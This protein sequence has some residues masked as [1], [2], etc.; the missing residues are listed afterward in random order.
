[1]AEVIDIKRTA[2]LGA[3]VMGAQIAALLANAG[4]EVVLLDRTEQDAAGGLERALQSRPP[5]FFTPGLAAQVKTASFADLSVLAEVDWIVEAI[6]E[7]LGIKQA[8]LSQVEEYAKPQAIISTNTSGLSIA[9]IAAVRG[10]AFNRRFLG[11]HFFNPP[12]YMRLV[13]FIAGP[14]TA[15]DIIEG[16]GAFVEDRLGKGVVEGRDTPNF[17]ANRLGVF[18]LMDVLHAM[19][20]EGLSV[21]EVDALT[22]PLLGRPRSASLRLCDIIGLDTLIH[23]ARTGYEKLS[24]DA[25]R[26]TF[27]PPAAVERMLDAGLLGEKSK[28]GF[29]RKTEQGI[30]ALDLANGAFRPLEAAQLGTLGKTA[31]GLEDR[32]KA[33]WADEGRLGAFARDHLLRVLLYA[34]EHAGEI[35]ADLVQI[36]RAM[37]WGF[38]WEAGPFELWDL[39]GVEEVVKHTDQVPDLVQQLLD[40]GQSHF[41]SRMGDRSKVFALANR[42][43]VEVPPDPGEQ[44]AR[45]LSASTAVLGNESAYLVEMDDDLGVLVLQGKMNVMR[46]QT[47]E[48]IQQVAASES[49]SGL[50]VYGAGDLFTA[51]ADLTHMAGLAAAGDWQG[52]DDFVAAFQNAIMALRYA[53]FPVVAAPRG[54]ALGGGCELCLAADGRIV[55]AESRLGLV[56]TRVGLIPGGG[57]CK[58]M[59]R[60]LGAGIEPG[61]RTI[62]AGAIADNALQA[63][64][65]LLLDADDAIAMNETTLVL[66]ALQEVKQLRVS[67]APPQKEPVRVAGAAGREVL[68]QWLGQ[69]VEAERLSLHDRKVGQRLAYV[70]CGGDRTDEIEEQD[71][72][73]LE[74]EAFLHLFGLEATRARIDHMLKTGKPLRN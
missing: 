13:E 14:A 55:A 71:L 27:L 19:E 49:L 37:K 38:N 7:D 73:D 52:L 11:I 51:G 16:M 64:Q 40:A 47:L 65:W 70:L 66:R 62:L 68:E 10:A 6:V 25:H 31:K 18:A 72:L 46:P 35:A 2:V 1:M 22:G 42:R 39:L 48:A 8:L 50:V 23:V 43:I 24:A 4:L 63:R 67:Y 17:I 61:F 41:Y 58:E 53:S 34:A 56:E 57:G 33:V 9:A 21:E 32:L 5:A 74:R 30:E 44:V 36:D 26:D 15:P 28:A 3:G 54:L 45:K 69:E 60:R 59:A 29:Y 20:R 12:R